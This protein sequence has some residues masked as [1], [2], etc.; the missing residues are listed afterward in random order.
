MELVLLIVVLAVGIGGIVTVYVNTVFGSADPLARKQAMA[1]AES[2]MD[3]IMLQ[4][5][6]LAPVTPPG[7]TRQTFDEISD[8][9]GYAT[10]GGIVDIYGVAVPGL[11]GYNVSS[12]SV[13]GTALNG[14]GAGDSALVTVTVA[15]PG[16][17]ISLEG[18]KLN[19]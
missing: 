3:E 19:Y 6:S 1:I 9:N 7:A 5:F 11:S 14:V 17:S 15:G 12:V 4:Q 18:Y 10:A 13:V 16:V 8:Y 2:L